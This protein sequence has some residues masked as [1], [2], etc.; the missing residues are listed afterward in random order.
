MDNTQ[1]IQYPPGFTV[2]QVTPQPDLT[3]DGLIWY[4]LRSFGAGEPRVILI[5]NTIPWTLA[6]ILVFTIIFS[7][8]FL[9]RWHK[10]TGKKMIQKIKKGR[11]NLIRLILLFMI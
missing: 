7:G 6:V 3:R 2:D 5:K 11:E 8:I 4:G 10:K 9:M 1:I